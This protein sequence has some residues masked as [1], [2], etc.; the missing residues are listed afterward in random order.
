MDFL[1]HAGRRWDNY[2]F[3]GWTSIGSN[4]VGRPGN[5]EQSRSSLVFLA[6]S[7]MRTR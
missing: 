1:E 7:A 4:D 5:V 2:T 6:Y 3:P